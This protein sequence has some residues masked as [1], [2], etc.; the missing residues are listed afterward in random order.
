MIFCICDDDILF[1]EELKHLL[2]EEFDETIQV[3][4]YINAY[5]VLDI[6]DSV[7]LL[8]LD[9][10]M[11]N[12]NGLE[13]LE[14]IAHKPVKK[15]MISNYDHIV[16]STYQYQLYWFIRKKHLNKDMKEFIIRLKRDMM[17][18]EKRLYFMSYNKAISIY[19]YLV[20]YI[21]THKNNLYIHT[22]E[23]CYKIRMTFHSLLKQI[24]EDLF[25]MPTYGV[26]INMNYITYIDFKKSIIL[27]NN[28]QEF[29]MSR[30]HQQEVRRK[31]G[32]FYS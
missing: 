16:F 6:I 8:F 7:D 32:K 21:T 9:Y 19:Q 1:M 12:L 10:D 22:D 18:R 31:Y 15:V 29:S 11:P 30:S 26:L 4:C 17:I 28:K 2:Y 27:L 5:D 25:I 14:K 3:I 24:D 13:I 23:Q 20:N